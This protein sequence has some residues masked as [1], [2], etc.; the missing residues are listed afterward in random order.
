VN[1]YRKVPDSSESDEFFDSENLESHDDRRFELFAFGLTGLGI[2]DSCS[3]HQSLV[4]VLIRGAAGSTMIRKMGRMLMLHLSLA[5]TRFRIKEV[6]EVFR[7]IG[8]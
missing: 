3:S 8:R 1:T 2:P 5:V 6:I 4:D 7:C